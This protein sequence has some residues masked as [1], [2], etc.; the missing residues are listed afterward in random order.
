MNGA[1]LRCQIA[2]RPGCTI[3]FHTRAQ[4]DGFLH[5]DMSTELELLKLPGTRLLWQGLQL[6]AWEA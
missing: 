1:L 6:A 3:P 4:T 5:P 2:A